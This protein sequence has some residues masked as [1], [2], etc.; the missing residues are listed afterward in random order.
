MV[1]TMM[2]GSIAPALEGPMPGPMQELLTQTQRLKKNMDTIRTGDRARFPETVTLAEDILR[3]FANEP[4]TL[5]AAYRAI[6]DDPVEIL[7][8]S[9]EVARNAHGEPVIRQTRVV[10]DNTRKMDSLKVQ[11]I[12]RIMT[13]LEETAGEN[14]RLK[15][16]L[17]QKGMQIENLARKPSGGF[18]LG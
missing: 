17:A 1:E 7:T 10:D 5:V 12:E 15:T 13:L 16:E 9:M 2:P 14:T 18:G 8:R 6:A 4:K 11:F 3:G